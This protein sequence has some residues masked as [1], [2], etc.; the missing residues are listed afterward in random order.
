MQSE[1][2]VTALK[3]N[4]NNVVYFCHFY[5]INALNSTITVVKT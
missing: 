1:A 2:L 5:V 3:F 4:K